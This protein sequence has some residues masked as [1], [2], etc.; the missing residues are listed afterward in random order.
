[1]CIAGIAGI[2]MPR[3]IRGVLFPPGTGV[4]PAGL[5]LYRKMP[6]LVRPL[7]VPRVAARPG[8]A[9]WENFPAKLPAKH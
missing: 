9:Y 8:A 5:A 1:M 4:R 2:I 3:R 7:R 6:I